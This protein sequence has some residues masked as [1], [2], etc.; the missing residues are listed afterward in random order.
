MVNYSRSV[1]NY[2]AV[3]LY[4]H[5]IVPFTANLFSALYIIFT[6]ARQRSAVRTN[7]RYREHILKQLKEHK[8]LLISPIILLVLSAPRLIISILS[9]C[10]NA[11][12]NPWLYLCA[13][14][15]S[16]TPSMLMFSAL[17]LPS[18]HYMKT[19]KE[20]LQKWKRKIHQ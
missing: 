18:E 9:G 1:E 12:D 20:S 6:T 17:V 15:I 19:F 4:F 2:Y 8:Q 5:L 3:V 7:Q 10:I 11:S 16:F 14:F 13:Y